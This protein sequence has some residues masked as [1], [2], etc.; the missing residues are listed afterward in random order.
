[1]AVHNKNVKWR[2]FRQEE[3]RVRKLRHAGLDS[4]ESYLQS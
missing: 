1:M 2:H 3:L 4:A